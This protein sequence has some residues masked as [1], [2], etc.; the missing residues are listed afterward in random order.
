MV[1]VVKYVHGL[2][3][4][5]VCVWWDHHIDMYIISIGVFVEA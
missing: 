5:F 4:M 1:K 2:V 3:L